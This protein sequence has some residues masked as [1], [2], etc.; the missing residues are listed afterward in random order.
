MRKYV[1]ALSI[2]ASAFL[3]HAD[4]TAAE[5]LSDSNKVFT[6]IMA[7]PDKGIPQDLLEKA[8]CVVIVPGM[9]Q[10]GF[11]VGG[12]FGKGYTVCRKTGGGWGAP[13]AIRVEGGSFGFQIGASSTDVVML[14]MNERGMGRLTVDKFTVGG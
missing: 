4:D 7:T 3:L 5:R 10:A 6:E 1:L 2:S 11:V 9:K 8:H 14:V 12:K 13:E